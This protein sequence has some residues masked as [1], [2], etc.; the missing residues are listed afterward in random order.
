MT[1]L[2]S[3]PFLLWRHAKEFGATKFLKPLHFG[4][5]PSLISANRVPKLQHPAE[6]LGD[7]VSPLPSH[8]GKSLSQVPWFPM[9]LGA[10]VTVPTLADPLSSAQ[11]AWFLHFQV[12]FKYWTLEWST[13]WK[14]TCW[15]STGFCAI[16]FYCSVLTLCVLL[17][18]GGSM[19]TRTGALG[20]WKRTLYP[21]ELQMLVS[22][23][24]LGAG[25]KTC[26]LC[27][28]STH[29]QSVRHPCS[30]GNVRHSRVY[31][32]LKSQFRICIGSITLP[33]TASRIIKSQSQILGF[34][35]KTRK[36]R[37]PSH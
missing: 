7:F 8:A 16:L 18:I 33:L 32:W 5:A 4:K 17:C 28:N 23:P 37:Q 15:Q 9:S 10:A 11:S 2:W 21:L 20:I 29:S 30:S 35:S 34:N 14:S 24:T 3:W 13:A 25:Y 6:T 36:A 22:C 31:N 19:H 27:K 1:L 26:L 12:L